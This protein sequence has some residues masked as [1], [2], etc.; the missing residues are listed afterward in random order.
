[1]VNLLEVLYGITAVLVVAAVIFVATGRLD[2][3]KRLAVA[4]FAAGAGSVILYVALA[5]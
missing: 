1:M 2:K 4:A 3:A 5:R